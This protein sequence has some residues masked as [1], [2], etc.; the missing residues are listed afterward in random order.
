VADNEAEQSALVDMVEIPDHILALVGIEAG[1]MELVNMVDILDYI[2]NSEVV[3]F[4]MIVQ[5]YQV[6][7][8]SSDLAELSPHLDSVQLFEHQ[9][10]VL[11][12]GVALAEVDVAFDPHSD[13]AC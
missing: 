10:E 6:R 3:L 12:V 7:L 1:Q 13:V 9:V 11:M 4:H 5:A 8:C 2:Q